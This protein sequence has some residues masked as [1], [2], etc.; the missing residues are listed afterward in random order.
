MPNGTNEGEFHD[1][2]IF[3]GMLEKR[4]TDDVINNFSLPTHSFF[5]QKLSS[6]EIKHL[7]EIN[8]QTCIFFVLLFDSL[9]ATSNFAHPVHYIVTKNN[10][11]NPFF[12]L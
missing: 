7:M 6:E 8:W 1:Q 4:A 9:Q 3:F 11:V 12:I 2:N 10:D 5:F